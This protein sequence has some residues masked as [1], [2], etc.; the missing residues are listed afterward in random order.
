M[1]QICIVVEYETNEGAEEEFTA[2]AM[3][4]ARRT[5]IEEPGCLRFDVTKPLDENGRPIAN[6]VMLNEIFTDEAAFA[7]H[8]DNP[9]LAVLRN[10]TA[11]LVK[12]RRRVVSNIV[13]GPAEETGMAPD[14]LNASNDG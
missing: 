9:R 14:Q 12:S 2:L 4:H 5:L 3:D 7:A 10:A 11:P 1:P 13:N 8:G 6:A